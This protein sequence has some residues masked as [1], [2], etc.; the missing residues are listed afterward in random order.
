MATLTMLRRGVVVRVAAGSAGAG[1]AATNDDMCTE[2]ERRHVALLHSLL[3]MRRLLLY[4]SFKKKNQNHP[5]KTYKS[6][7]Q[8]T[9]NFYPTSRC[10]G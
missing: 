3:T 6:Q 9:F 5:S 10:V 2:R 1:R 8:K 7:N 4:H